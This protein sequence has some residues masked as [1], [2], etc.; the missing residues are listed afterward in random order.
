MNFFLKI[1][2]NV[3]GWNWKKNQFKELVKKKNS[4]KNDKWTFHRPTRTKRDVTKLMVDNAQ[5]F[6]LLL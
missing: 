2:L 5:F 1:I 6:M 4:T 3:K